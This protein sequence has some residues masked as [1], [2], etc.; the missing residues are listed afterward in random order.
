LDVDEED[1]IREQLAEVDA[2]IDGEL[3]D[4]NDRKV[5]QA[6]EIEPSSSSRDDTVR[7]EPGSLT[8]VGVVASEGSHGAAPSEAA[9]EDTNPGQPDS[10]ETAAT[11]LR[12]SEMKEADEPGKESDDDH[13]E[14]VRGEEDT[15][16]Y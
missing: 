9:N 15:V 7:Q 8:S 14:L 11:N 5:E 1:Q 10:A 6:E 2:V 13:D 12:D 3:Q 16:L 4:F